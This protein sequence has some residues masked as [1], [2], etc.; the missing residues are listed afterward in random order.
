MTTLAL[1]PLRGGS[2]SI[3]KKNIKEI[4]GKPLCAWVLEAASQAAHIDAVYVST[5]S[6]EIEA[7]VDSLHLNVKLIQRPSE[8][9][10]DEASTESVML[11]FMQ[12][13]AFDN[14]V[15]IQA[16]S[17]LLL[18][19]HLDD[20]LQQFQLKNLDS[21]LSAVRT[22]R[23][24]WH[25][26]GTAFNYDPLN[27]PRRQEF[28]GTLMENGAFYITRRYILEKYQCRLGGKIGIYEMPENSAVEIDELDDWEMVAKLL[29]NRCIK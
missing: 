5:D 3:P 6:A 15:T 11:H 18:S 25:D 20:A 21:M 28:T 10:T 4:A 16:T 1:I 2:K 19:E 22:K 26:N 23:F 7:V 9:A 24:F 13:V 12:Q 17:P 14:L 8:L 27:R 29:Q